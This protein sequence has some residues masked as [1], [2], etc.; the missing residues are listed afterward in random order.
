MAGSLAAMGGAGAGGMDIQALMGGVVLKTLEATEE[1]LDSE[2]ERLD[3]VDEDDIERLRRERMETLRKGAAERSK[4]VAAGHGSYKDCG[5][6]QKAFFEE[7]KKETRAVVHFYRASTRRCEIVDK[8][9]D[10]LARKHI[11]TKFMRI[12]A[13]RS[14]FVVE[15]L[16]VVMLPTIML[17]RNN[18]TDHSKTDHSIIGFDEMGRRDDFATETLEAL[19]LAHGVLLEA[20]CN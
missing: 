2:L 13:E 1:K 11:E 9:L 12:D 5:G 7:L 16:R 15:R 20:Y 19:L 17:V 10:I 14:P 18:K 3:K 4:W 6:D 8:H